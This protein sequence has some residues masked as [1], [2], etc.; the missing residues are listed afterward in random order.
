MSRVSKV[1]G[2]AA[3]L[4]ALAFGMASFASAQNATTARDMISNCEIAVQLNLAPQSV[5]Q[6]QLPAAAFCMGWAQGV[7]DG[8]TA[9]NDDLENATG[10]GQ[11]KAPHCIADDRISIGEAVT[12]FLDYAETRPA[13][14]S[15]GEGQ[16][17]FEA[18]AKN[19]PC[20]PY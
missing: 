7:L 8:I 9:V 14:I 16:M 6:D 12:A 5:S 18:L 1:L 15:Q 17:L 19:Y 11:L 20:N 13:S 4:S 2:R 3:T 10:T